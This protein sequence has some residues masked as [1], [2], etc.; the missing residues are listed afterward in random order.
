MSKTQE[1][2]RLEQLSAPWD[3]FK[4]TIRSD[5]QDWAQQRAEPR[6]GNQ[7]PQ[8]VML[9]FSFGNP[10]TKSNSL[11]HR[12]AQ[13]AS[14]LASLFLFSSGRNWTS[15]LCFPL[16]TSLETVSFLWLRR[17]V[18]PLNQINIILM[19][20]HWQVLDSLTRW[21]TWLPSLLWGFETP[22][23][24]RPLGS[25]R[26][27]APDLLGFQSAGPCVTFILPLRPPTAD[28]WWFFH[29]S[30]WGGSAHRTRVF[31]IFQTHL[32]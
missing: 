20:H 18:S 2:L 13:G 24:P 14:T 23:I 8:R 7:S 10:S 31:E 9:L 6:V 21:Q 4:Q 25:A 30:P 28:L 11:L 16:P 19:D 5:K 3:S 29:S 22:R 15:C 12:F 1:N 17:Q 27:S 26:L 32:K